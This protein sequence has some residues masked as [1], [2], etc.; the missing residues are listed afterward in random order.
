MAADALAPCI[1]RTSAAMILRNMQ[2]ITEYATTSYPEH[3]CYPF[4]EEHTLL[5]WLY[6]LRQLVS[7]MINKC[8][9]CSRC[10]LGHAYQIQCNVCCLS[11]HVN[12]I[13][14]NPDDRNY[15]TN[16]VNDWICCECISLT[17]PF[18]NIMDNSEFLAAINHIDKSLSL[19]ASNLI[20]HPF[21]INDIDHTS[22]LCDIDPDLY[23]YNSIDFQLSSNCNYYDE[24]TFA[25]NKTIQTSVHQNLSLCHLNIRSMQKNL[26][27]FAS[28]I[29]SLN[30]AFSVIGLS[31]TWLRDDTCGLYD[32]ENYTMIEK[33]RDTKSGG[34]VGLFINKQLLFTERPDL[35]CFDEYMECVTVELYCDKIASNN[36]IIISVIYRPPNTDTRIFIDKLSELLDSVRHENKVCYF[37]GDYNINILNYE[38]HRATADFVDILYSYAIFPLINRPTRITSNSATLIDNIFTNNLVALEKSTNG[39]LVT[40]I[41]DHFPVFHIN[42]YK[43]LMTA[44]EAFCLSRNFS[45]RNKQAFRNALADLDFSEIYSQQTIQSSFSLFHSMIIDTYNKSFPKRKIKIRY[46]NRKPWLTDALKQSIRT[47]N[48]LYMKYLKIKSSHNEC[49]YKTYRNHLTRVLKCAEKK[50]YADLLEAL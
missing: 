20:F 43:K 17:L 10:I 37:L 31:E 23:F 29:E 39:I 25:G 44:N 19:N 16:Q 35:C 26:S 5:F 9:I 2:P 6:M 48:K 47:K 27:E 49:K 33:H 14:I 45:Q 12:C 7:S 18:N 8:P 21:E 28:Y 50:H 42:P 13:S 34:G 11:Y 4:C 30:F 3:C 41:S 1:A 22:P 32:M 46:H 38:T 15:L 24:S 36:T 40:D